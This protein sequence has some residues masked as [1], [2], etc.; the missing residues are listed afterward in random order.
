MEELL[1]L[2]KT[3]KSLAFAGILSVSYLTSVSASELKFFT[4]GTGGTAYT[5]YPVGGMIANAISKPP[6]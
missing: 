5:Y 6:G 3:I 2:F 4:I 1:T